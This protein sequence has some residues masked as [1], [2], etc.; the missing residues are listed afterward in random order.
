MRE[1]NYSYYLVG[2]TNK[3]YKIECYAYYVGAFNY[4]WHDDVECL[5][6]L[7][8]K[9]EA[10][11]DGKVYRLSKG[12]ICFIDSNS[13]HATLS[14]EKGTIALVLHFNPKI[15]DLYYENRDKYRWNMA[16]DEF[17]RNSKAAKTIKKSFADIVDSFSCENLA[18]VLK[19]NQATEKI[20]FESIE[21][22]AELTEVLIEDKNSNNKDENI[23]KL[24]DYLDKNYKKKINLNDLA[25]LA[26][27]HP[28]YTSEIFSE[29]VGVTFTEY[30]LRKRLSMATK[31]LKQSE[32]KITDI[33]LEHGFANVRAFN[34]AFKESFGRSPSEYRESLDKDTLEIDAE[35]KKVFL[36]EDNAAWIEARDFWNSEEKNNFKIIRE[37][38]DKLRRDIYREIIEALENKID[39]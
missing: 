32:K 5:V 16:T 10:C 23:R 4:N 6:V 30:L 12:D 3:K 17:S 8:G 26:G 28:N 33:A 24:I 35:F 36:S 1:L 38:S 15:L 2:D 31:D 14:K 19:R 18:N 22:F 20:L 9:L 21:N 37:D 13:G 11:Y 27:Y 25:K 39:E 29:S 34:K 7:S